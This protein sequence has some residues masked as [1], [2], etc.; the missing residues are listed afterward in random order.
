[1]KHLVF[2][3]LTGLLLLL[4][5][6]VSAQHA[7]TQTAPIRITGSET[8]ELANI[9]LALTPYGQQDPSEVAKNSH[10]YQEVRT[11]FAPYAQHPLLV[12]VN[13]SRKEWD[14]YLSFRTD[15]YA[16]AF[17]EQGQL[18]RQFPFYA[19]G[20]SHP[21]DENLALITDFV[22]TSGF[23][24]FYQR[25]QPYYDSLTV[26]YKASQRLPEVLSFLGTELGNARPDAQ[27]AI[28]FSPLVGR[29]NCHRTVNQVATDFISLPEFLLNRTAAKA[30]SVTD[31]A[32]GI[33][34]LFTEM[35]H[36]FVNPVTDQYAAQVTAAFT[37]TKWDS[38][39]GYEKD[40]FGT[41]NEYMTWAVYDLFVYQY[42]P[43]IAPQVCQ[44][45]GMQ[46]ESRGFFASNLFNDKLRDLYAHR[47]KGQTLR[48]LYPALLKWCA[49]T[50]LQL[51]LPTIAHCSL[52]DATLTTG[53]RAHYEVTF[54]EPMQET[55]TVDIFHIAKTEPQKRER[56][57]L[58][59]A[60]HNLRWSDHGQKLAFDLELANNCKNQ[61]MFNVPW[62]TELALKSKK[63][64][65]IKIYGSSISTEV[66]A[67]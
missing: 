10:Y 28:V 61:V 22:Q 24:A 57:A 60:T 8:Y 34:L 7:A 4:G 16:F 55:P 49:Q 62:N 65:D 64:V 58:T 9:I 67:N 39:S 47:K 31:I 53:L 12:Q 20:P 52:Q 48:D 21:F 11:Q 25:H 46:N 38:G 63:G 32:S 17:S 51:S 44:D 41:F 35:D 23:R 26:A 15:A 45:W 36:G 14:K 27:Y 1:L 59:Q 18:S 2:S 29:M 50:Q 43:Q 40:P 13:Y 42:F 5:F 19:Q 37:P 66:K 30:P 6:S 3:F 33:H 54:S 56:V